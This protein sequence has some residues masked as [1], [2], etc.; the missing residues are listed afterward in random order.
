MPWWLIH[1]YL[2]QSR[3]REEEA[4]N[5]DEQEIKSL[6]IKFQKKILDFFLFSENQ[7]AKLEHS[8]RR[9]A[10]FVRTCQNI[11]ASVTGFK[12]GIFEKQIIQD[13]LKCWSN[14]PSSPAAKK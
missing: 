6:E 9:L 3:C 1:K 10:W 8:G 13:K 2:F 5:T 7:I 4:K 12:P 11:G 14:V